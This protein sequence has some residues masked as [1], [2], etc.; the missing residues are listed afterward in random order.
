[1]SRDGI[2]EVG[3]DSKAVSCIRNLIKGYM[4]RWGGLRKRRGRV[5]T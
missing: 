1:M 2:G 5:R 4:D 3:D